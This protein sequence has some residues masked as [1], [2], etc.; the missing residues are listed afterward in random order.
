MTKLIEEHLAKHNALFKNN[1]KY[2]D[3]V[4]SL[5]NTKEEHTL[6]GEQFIINRDNNAKLL[7][8]LIKNYPLMINDLHNK[9]GLGTSFYDRKRK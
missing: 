7:K 2:Q 8:E 4:K 5:K 6:L 3:M 9:P 1:Q